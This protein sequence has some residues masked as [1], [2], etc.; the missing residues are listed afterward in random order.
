MTRLRLPLLLCAVSLLLVI[1]SAQG[2]TRPTFRVKPAPAWVS[3]GPVDTA[4]SMADDAA[5]GIFY[6]LEDHQ[7][8][9]S[10]GS[11]ERYYHVAYRVISQAGLE[12]GSQIEPEFDPTYE[13]LV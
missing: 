4:A 12:P 6:L 1:R 3:A 13:E 2:A 9:V 10:E 8:R 7:Q 5:S 11:T